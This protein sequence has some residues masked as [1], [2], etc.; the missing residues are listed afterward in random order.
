MIQKIG[1]V[2]DSKLANVNTVNVESCKENDSFDKSNR[3][4]CNCS[5]IVSVAS[6]VLSLIVLIITLPR[7]GNLQFDYMGFIVGVLAIIVTLLIGW[8]IFTNI[9]VERTLNE[10]IKKQ[11]QMIQKELKGL[12]SEISHRTSDA[13]NIA[14]ALSLAQ[15]GISQVYNEDF[16]N[17]IRSLMN[18]L[19]F[20]VKI[21]DKDEL[22]K[23]VYSNVTEKIKEFAREHEQVII[24]N[25]S[26]EEIGL[27]VDAAIKT[28][29][30]E[31]IAFTMR[32][33]T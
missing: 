26:Q 32:F 25:L 18:A 10:K 8:Q 15:M 4:K 5:V 7:I 30:I 17:A 27:F 12:E 11:H 29:D 24:T 22:Y 16:S 14:M 23:E 2:K 33:K 3:W 31:I 9:T 20:C 19:I 21:E 6:F 28:N 1:D 13:S